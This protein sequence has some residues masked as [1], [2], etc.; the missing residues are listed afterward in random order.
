MRKNKVSIALMAA[1]VFMALAALSPGRAEA[2]DIW[3]AYIS[4]NN[5]LTGEGNGVYVGGSSN[6]TDGY[7][8]LEDGYAWGGG[9]MSTYLYHQEWGRSSV[10]G[11]SDYYFND[12]RSLNFP[13]EWKIYQKY[14]VT[15]VDVVVKWNL[16]GMKDFMRCNGVVGLILTDTATGRRLEMTEGAHYTYY[17]ASA[18][19]GVFSVTASRTTTV[20]PLPVPQN[21]VSNSG[22]GQVVLRW[23][24]D[25]TVA[26]YRVY[27]DGTLVSG[28]MLLV[29]DDGNG[30]V[31][32]VDKSA[33]KGEGKKGESL[34]S[35]YSV[36][37]VGQNG[38][39]SAPASVEVTR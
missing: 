6:S 23:D 2:V 33:P 9:S 15:G 28:D 8:P 31:A 17:N 3:K 34:L 1:Y 38:C 27:R 32:F 11:G 4:F 30:K 37:S 24:G 5:A 13:Q 25:T 26:G 7:D 14:A 21:L 35:A 36:V 18:G 10:P 19:L 16:G 20:A 12:I 22:E 39:E 29:D